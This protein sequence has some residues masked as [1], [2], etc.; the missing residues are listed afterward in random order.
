MVCLFLNR[1]YMKAAQICGVSV[2]LTDGLVGLVQVWWKIMKNEMHH[3]YHQHM[4]YYK[5]KILFHSQE[6][7]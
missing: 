3:N 5:T 6:T 4:N 7:W 1:G 2:V